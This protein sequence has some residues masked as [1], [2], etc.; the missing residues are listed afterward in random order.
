[1][2]SVWG[3]RDYEHR[4]ALNALKARTYNDAEPVRVSAYPKMIDPFHWYGVV[5]TPAF[6]GM[7]PVDS[8]APEVDPEGELE[9]RFKPE[10]T[11]VTL[12]A[13]K[14]YA[15]RVFLDWAQYPIAETEVLPPPREGYIVHFRDLRYAGSLGVVRGSR[16][17]SPLGQAVELD[18]NLRIVGDVVGVGENQIVVPE[19]GQRGN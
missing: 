6:Y 10:E 2:A 14:S 5:E 15:G 3:V 1:V 19:P 16:N 13:K 18:K 4:R 9:V 12:A 7:M 8:L 17:R 11:P